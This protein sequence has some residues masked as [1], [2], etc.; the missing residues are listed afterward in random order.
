MI[1]KLDATK[2]KEHEAVRNSVRYYDFTH[3]MIEVTGPQSGEILDRVSSY[4]W[5]L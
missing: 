4:T 2:R 5:L 1:S 3:E